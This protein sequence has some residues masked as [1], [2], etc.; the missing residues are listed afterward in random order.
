MYILLYFFF[1]FLMIRRPPRSTLSSSSAASDVYKRQPLIFM[2]RKADVMFLF[3][4][5]LKLE[6]LQKSEE[7]IQ[8]MKPLPGVRVD[9]EEIWLTPESARSPLNRWGDREL[10]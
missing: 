9:M 1:F 7:H 10:Q 8:N 2:R 4:F 6:V 5:C 3:D